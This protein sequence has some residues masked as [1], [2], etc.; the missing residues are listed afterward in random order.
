LLY[1]G[2]AG[3]GLY[4]RPG[5]QRLSLVVRFARA[6]KGRFAA[7]SLTEGTIKAL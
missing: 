7:R 3:S 1:G 2:I 6:V 5:R 4:G